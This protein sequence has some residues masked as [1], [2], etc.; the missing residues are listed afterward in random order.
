LREPLAIALRRVLLDL[1]TRAEASRIV[2]NGSSVSSLTHLRILCKQLT[3]VYEQVKYPMAKKPIA[4]RVAPAYKQLKTP[5][6]QAVTIR[7]APE[8]VEALERVAKEVGTSRSR[9]LELAVLEF[10][11]AEK[12]APTRYERKVLA[13]T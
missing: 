13:K 8:M 7:L 1:P 2:N 4:E 9:L 3:T 10:A 6:T 11:K 12:I 5:R